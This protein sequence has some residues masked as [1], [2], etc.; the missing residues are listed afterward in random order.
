MCVPWRAQGSQTATFRSQLSPLPSVPGIKPRSSG[1]GSKWF[2]SMNHPNGPDWVIII[3]WL[4]LLFIYVYMYI[5]ATC[6]G[7][8]IL[9]VSREH[10]IPRLESTCSC[11]STWCW[12]LN[13]GSVK[14]QQALFPRPWLWVHRVLPAFTSRM[15][16]LKAHATT[17]SYASSTPNPW[18]ISQVVFKQI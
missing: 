9:K 6:T 11:H 5:C 12:E 17:P 2:Y 1:L 13:S 18:A 7:A 3:F 15:W 8:I 10:Q 16:G 14:E 4:V